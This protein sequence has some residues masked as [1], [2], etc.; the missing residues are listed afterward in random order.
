[1]RPIADIPG[2]SMYYKQFNSGWTGKDDLLTFF[3]CSFSQAETYGDRLSYNWLCSGW[4]DGEFSDHE[5]YM[6]FIK[7]LYTAGQVG[8]V[9]GY[10]SH[11][12]GGFEKDVGEERP[13]WLRQ[14]MILGRAQALFSH[15]EDFIRE[16][17]LLAGPEKHSLVKSRTDKDLP[18]YE[19]PT[20]DANARVLARKHRNRNEWLVTAWA[21]DGK[22][23]EIKVFID[24]IG[25]LKLLARPS[26]SVYRVSVATQ[27]KHEPP[28][29]KFK[30]IDKHPMRPS[31]GMGS[32]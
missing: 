25:E 1:M 21:A 28:E 24:E 10:F 27:T 29:I 15:L 22:A 32:E 30:L 6:G 5:R 19:F 8:A 16:G 18:A 13:H 12:K 11:P 9:A 23:R 14:M 26:G 2:Q 31:A 4:K 7:C 3:L 20:G 17:D